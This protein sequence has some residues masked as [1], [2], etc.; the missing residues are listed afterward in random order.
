[1]G[2]AESLPSA[3]VVVDDATRK[4]TFYKQERM[5]DCGIACLRMVYS[6]ANEDYMPPTNVLNIHS[7]LWTIDLLG[8]LLNSKSIVCK[9][10]TQ[11]VG[12][13]PHHKEMAWY[14]S[15][16]NNDFTRIQHKFSMNWPVFIEK[17]SLST[18]LIALSE[19]KI[20]IVLVDSKSLQGQNHLQ[21]DY[22]GHFIVV[23]GYS[24]GQIIYLDPS[25]ADGVECRI[26]EADFEMSRSH[27]GTDHDIIICSKADKATP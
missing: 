11:S 17:I 3:S 7:P 27:E 21:N 18:I 25:S 23:T 4:I 8:E 26:F 16:S 22:T 15:N 24:D 13:Q 10:Y 1:M 2:A 9:M 20:A 14:T 6:W 12:V 19:G 5:W